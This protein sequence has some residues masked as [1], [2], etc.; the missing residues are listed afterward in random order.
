[1]GLTRDRY[2][3]ELALQSNTYLIGAVIVDQDYWP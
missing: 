3:L 2:F 1:M